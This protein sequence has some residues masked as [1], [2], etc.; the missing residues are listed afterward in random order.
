MIFFASLLGQA[1]RGK[2][3]EII[4]LLDDVIVQVG[5][6][7]YPPITGLVVRD[8]RR[9]FFVAASQLE[10][11]NGAIRLGTSTVNLR[12]FLRRDGE[13]LLGK[14]VLDHQIIDISGRRI[15][16][17]NDVQLAQIERVYRIVGVDVSAKALLRRLGPR[18]LAHR[19]VGRQIIDW[20]E[21]QYLASDAPVR[22]KV[23][24]DRLSEMNP[25]DLGRIVDALSFR[26]SAEIVAALDNETVAET[27]E[28][29]SD[30]R[31]ADLLEG[32]DKERA[33]DILEEMN[34]GAAAD[35]LEDLD[36]DLAEQILARMEPEEAAEIQEMLAYDEDS[37]GRIMRSD[38]VHVAEDASV[39]SALALLRAM[40]E[41]PDPLP[42]IYVV[43]RQ[44]ESGHETNTSEERLGFRGIVRLRSLIVAKP[45]TQMVE[46]MEDDLPTINHSAKAEDATRLLAEYNLLA[47]PVLDDTDSMIGIVTV[48]DALAVLLPEIWQRRR[49]NVFS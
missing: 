27:L 2:A 38:F 10:S 36:R 21:A 19:I 37:V 18:S 48:D 17:V 11:F 1:V 44:Q 41:V 34:P 22:L 6:D 12:P 28:E 40:D 35:A 42:A 29:V 32:M 7:L 49:E 4:G 16:R 26:E 47:I 20:Q 9:Q 14:D 46:I 24:Y 5:D 13:I 39:G 23:S 15:V 25:V 3:N 33:A 8:R 43:T 31:V 30:E 45:E